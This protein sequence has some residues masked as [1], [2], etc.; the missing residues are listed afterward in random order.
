[1]SAPVV[2]APAVLEAVPVGA[3]FRVRV[4]R[5]HGATTALLPQLLAYTRSAFTAE[6]ATVQLPL[7]DEP[8]VADWQEYLAEAA[9]KGAWHCLRNRLAQLQFPI[10]AGISR[11]EG[12]ARATRQGRSGRSTDA[13]E[14]EQPDALTLLLHPT[15]AGR[16]PVLVA[17][18]RQDF[19]SLVRAFVYRNEPVPVADSIGA[20]IVGG[21]TNWHRVNTQRARWEAGD[22]FREHADWPSALR[23]ISQHRELYQDRFILLSRG[24]YSNVA[25]ASLEL[26]ESEWHAAS[27]TIRLEHECT[28]YFTRRVFGSMKNALHDELIADYCG[29]TAA[30]GR[31][32][33]DWFLRFMGLENF[34]AYRSGGRLE[35]YRGSPP[36]SAEGFKVLQSVM[37]AA[38]W[39]LT[40][41][42]AAMQC[43]GRATP[44]ERAAVITFLARQNLEALADR[45]SGSTASETRPSVSRVGGVS[46]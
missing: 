4:L 30:A 15:P 2:S 44:S 20:C 14:L 42:D 39:G 21:Y 45:A 3:R 11:T 24:P 13:L 12:Y 19:V 23:A 18:T 29:I 46:Y 33:A 27:L 22:V 38:A 6:S 7:P 9:Q 31:F 41:W 36:L 32:R 34:P 8:F 16:I 35:N 37:Y 26:S 17:G 43:G 25:A 10:R 1:V 28:H 5:A 40:R